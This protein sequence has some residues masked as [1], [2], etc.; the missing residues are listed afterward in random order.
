MRNNIFSIAQQQAKT[1]SS[2]RIFPP[3]SLRP[4]AH[5]LSSL[6]RQHFHRANIWNTFAAVAKGQTFGIICMQ[7]SQI[8]YTRTCVC[9]DGCIYASEGCPCWWQFIIS[10]SVT[11]VTTCYVLLPWPGRKS[12]SLN[13]FQQIQWIFISVANV[14]DLFLPHFRPFHSQSQWKKNKEYFL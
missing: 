2:H 13:P 9:V 1:L 5:A 10:I 3:W 7:K 14:H 8:I 12:I 6:Y 11:L 4:L